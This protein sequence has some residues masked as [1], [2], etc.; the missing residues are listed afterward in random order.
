[1]GVRLGVTAVAILCCFATIPDV[2]AAYFELPIT[3]QLKWQTYIS[4]LNTMTEVI[5][6]ESRRV[7]GL[8]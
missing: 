3:Q 6:I 7:A 1:M 4:Q 5:K 8:W 2:R